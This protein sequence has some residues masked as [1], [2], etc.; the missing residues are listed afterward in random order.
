MPT[1]A[2]TVIIALATIAPVLAIPTPDNSSPPPPAPPSDRKALY[3]DLFTAPTALD[4]YQRLL[5][6]PASGNL[7]GGDAL[8]SNIV[9]DY[10][11]G[12]QLSAGDKGGKIT[13]A[14]AAT[15]PILVNQ[16]ISTVT[17]FL[18]PCR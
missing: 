6:D 14:V 13:A 8:R 16:D 15:F 18:N 10:N 1:F 17:A 11:T 4:R 5:V 7:L 3:A 9:F 12:A 2:T